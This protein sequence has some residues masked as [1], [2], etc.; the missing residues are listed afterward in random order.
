[1]TQRRKVNDSSLSSRW[2]ASQQTK[3]TMRMVNKTTAHSSIAVDSGI[4]QKDFA[5]T[6]HIKIRKKDLE[7]LR[8]GTDR[9][10][11]FSLVNHEEGDMTK[12]QQSTKQLSSFHRAMASMNEYSTS[13]G[14]SDT[15]MSRP[16]TVMS[17]TQ[18]SRKFMIDKNR[19]STK[20]RTYSSFNGAQQDLQKQL[21]ALNS[22]V[23]VRNQISR[24]FFKE[25]KK[26]K[27]Q[28]AVGTR[29][30]RM[31]GIPSRR[32]YSR[33][34]TDHNEDLLSMTNNNKRQLQQNL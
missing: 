26:I 11:K 27:P 9:K 17:H 29:R 18:E 23:T 7:I 30:S 10:R 31:T 1:M 2:T 15:N 8:T 32:C 20:R 34:E 25:K 22:E 28:T 33:L 21:N 14:P 4:K 13:A 12:R 5:S 6:L 16:A 3:T 19:S 24:C